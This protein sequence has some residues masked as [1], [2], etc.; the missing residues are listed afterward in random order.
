MGSG[1]KGPEAR[2]SVSSAV[3]HGSC[4]DSN[5]SNLEW[6]WEVSPRVPQCG[7]DQAW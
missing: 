2:R 1:M 5:V 4:S 7:T 3:F 6:A